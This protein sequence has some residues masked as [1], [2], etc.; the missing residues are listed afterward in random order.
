MYTEDIIVNKPIFIYSS[1]R[2]SSIDTVLI[3]DDCVL[4]G[5]II[6]QVI[7][8]KGKNVV[9]VDCIIESLTI[10]NSCVVEDCEIAKVHI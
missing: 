2:D 1:N 9:I 10:S 7:I 6:E 8:G 3:Q 5:L 4:Y